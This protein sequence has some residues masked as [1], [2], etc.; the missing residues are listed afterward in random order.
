MHSNRR[1]GHSNGFVYRIDQGSSD[2]G[3]HHRLESQEH[4]PQCF[5]AAV[6]IVGNPVNPALLGRGHAGFHR[7]LVMG[8]GKLRG[9]VTT[10]DVLRAVVGEVPP[11]ERQGTIELMPE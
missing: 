2:T 7:A 8:G 5:A 6:Y 9:I 11:A 10:V 3:A 4:A 1:H